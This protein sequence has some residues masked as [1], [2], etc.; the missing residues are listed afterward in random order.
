MKIAITTAGTN[1]T[2]AV[3]LRF[4]RAK[5]FAIYDTDTKELTFIDNS[6]QL[7][8]A[9]GAGI[10]AA[11]HVVASGATALISGHCGPKAMRVLQAKNIAVYVTKEATI[12]EALDALE[13][14]TLEQITQAD[15]EEHWV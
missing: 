9:Q 10:Q 7:N 15:V 12:Q 6:Q 14:G 8:A 3:E 13:A 1:L 11:Q 2:D 5:S 4:G